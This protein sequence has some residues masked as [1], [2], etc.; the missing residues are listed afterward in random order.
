M[1]RYRRRSKYV[2]TISYPRV[3][4]NGNKKRNQLHGELPLACCVH[5]LV[6]SGICSWF[7]AAEGTIQLLTWPP[8]RAPTFD[9]KL[10]QA[11]RAAKRRTP[12]QKKNKSRK[13]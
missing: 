13:T 2:H 1:D 5:L 6:S 9:E 7:V 3:F 12:T 4:K 10:V 8:S 11:A